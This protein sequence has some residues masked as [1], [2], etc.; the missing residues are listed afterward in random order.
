MDS[1]MICIKGTKHGLIILINP[2]AVFSEIKIELQEKMAA[3]N[4]FFNGAKFALSY[5][6]NFTEDET[7]AL[8]EICCA[9]G[10]IPNH[11]LKEKLHQDNPINL[12]VLNKENNHMDHDEKP[13]PNT[14]DACLL[15][16]KNIRNGEEIIYNGNITILGD[17]NPGAKLIATGNILVMGSL[18]GVAHAGASGNREA[19][20][21][22]Y[23]LEP[24]QI[25]IADC[26]AC[27]SESNK[28]ALYPEIAQLNEQQIMIEE[29]ISTRSNLR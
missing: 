5:D 8:E 10:L 1:E 22:A 4:G 24:S 2:S 29:Y 25:R 18:R 12:I 28:K 15:L 3:A 23:L 6:E 16:K 14:E 26:I 13:D 27:S 17:V 20:I 19:K 9:H 11:E 7:K 21:I